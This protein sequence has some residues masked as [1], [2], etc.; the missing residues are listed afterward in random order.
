MLKLS[1]R[2]KKKILTS[3]IAAAI[4][5]ALIAVVGFALMFI[6]EGL[7]KAVG[8]FEG[9]GEGDVHFDLQKVDELGIVA[10]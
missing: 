7:G 2:N 6:R 10:E 5:L 8:E 1:E 4:F 9:G 3:T